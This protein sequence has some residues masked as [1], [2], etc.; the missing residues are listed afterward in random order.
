MGKFYS[1]TLEQGLLL[2]YF[3]PDK[4]KYPK[5][6]ELI[7][8]A[9]DAGEP[10]AFYFLARCYAWGDGN[11]KADEKKARRLSKEGIELGSDLCV[12]GA[13]RF[14]G[15]KGDVA[16]A[17]KHSLADS[18]EAVKQKAMAGDPMAQYAVALFYFWG[19]IVE[20]CPP[21]P[22]QSI[23]KY[24]TENSLES[25]RWYR[26]AARQGCIPALENLYISLRDGVNGIPKNKQAALAVAEE[27]VPYVNIHGWLYRNIGN[28]YADLGNGAKAM[29]WYEEGI[30]RLGDSDCANDLGCIFFYGKYGIA[31]NMAQGIKYFRIGAEK[32]EC[33]AQY[34]LAYAYMTGSGVEQDD[35]KAFTYFKESAAQGHRGSQGRLAQF[36]YEGRGGV[37][38]DYRAS[39]EWGNRA[40]AQGDNNGRLYLGKCYLYGKGGMKNT[41]L[42]LRLFREA[43]ETGKC[44]AAY[45]ELGFMYDRGEGVQENVAQAA[46]YYKL[47]ADGGC[48]SAKD[49]LARFKKSLFGGWKRK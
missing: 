47:A 29:K 27:L 36:Y 41:E 20:I 34:N 13:D 7:Q 46:E 28:M 43:A 45:R 49:D 42:A 11:M 35:E 1:D 32:G 24:E 38:V 31:K 40:S 15:L 17:M 10:D 4:A 26:M 19:D 2:L 14:N 5:G 39:S 30:N 44:P 18:F 48:D 33:Y 3:Q 9:A 23:E 22:G 37:P 16:A 8:K 12:L 25:H 6:L 21:R